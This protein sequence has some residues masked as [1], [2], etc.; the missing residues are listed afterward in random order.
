L[1]ADRIKRTVSQLV[2]LGAFF[3]KQNANGS[4]KKAFKIGIPCAFSR[5]AGAGERGEISYKPSH[6]ITAPKPAKYAIKLQSQL[7]KP[8]ATSTQKS[9][10][11]VDKLLNSADKRAGNTRGPSTIYD[12]KAGLKLHPRI[13]IR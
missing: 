13:L 5:T 12:K 11:K 9:Q 3:T 6:S 2:S 7:S 4:H 1:F 10:K 8:K